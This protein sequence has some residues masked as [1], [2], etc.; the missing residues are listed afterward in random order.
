MQ[1]V[2]SAAEWMNTHHDRDCIS[3]DR[4]LCYGV[5]QVSEML[6]NMGE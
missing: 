6:A 2:E 4:K 5:I 3:R 1:G